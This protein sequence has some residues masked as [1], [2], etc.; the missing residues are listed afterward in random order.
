MWVTPDSRRS[1]GNICITSHHLHSTF[2]T[3]S[4]SSPVS[5][6]LTN[7]SHTF[8]RLDFGGSWRRDEY[9]PPLFSP[10]FF[11]NFPNFAL[12]EDK[13]GELRAMGLDFIR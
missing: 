1:A 6:V 2:S 3:T 13:T 9:R 4:D 8:S 7:S 5:F 11:L 10:T 12:I